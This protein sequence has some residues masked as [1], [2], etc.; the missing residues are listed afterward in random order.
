[1]NVVDFLSQL[2]PEWWLLGGGLLFLAATAIWAMSRPVKKPPV[3]P[4]AVPI[5]DDGRERLFKEP[6]PVDAP[7]PPPGL[8]ERRGRLRRKGTTVEVTLAVPGLEVQPWGGVV[9]DRSAGGLRVL[10]GRPA[11]PGDQLVV[12]A[13][14]APEGT[15]WAPVEVVHCEES[16][17]GWVLRCRFTTDL[18]WSVLLLFG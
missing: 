13:N 9:K 6:P 2:A 7:P 5:D 3:A 8:E 15:P 18:P 12:R 4:A 16:G 14:I 11:K 10:S 17:T 1:M